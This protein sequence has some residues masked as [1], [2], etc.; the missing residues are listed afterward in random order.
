MPS[1]V[2]LREDDSAEAL[3][4]L[5]RRSKD[6]NRNRRLLSWAVVRDGM[7]RGSAAQIGAMD[8]Q[9]LR[10]WVHRFNA[11]GPDELIRQLDRGPRAPPVRRAAGCVRPDCR[12][13]FGSRPGPRRALAADRPQAAKQNR[14]EFSHMSGRRP[15]SRVLEVL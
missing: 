3:Q 9:T 10:D 6:V 14:A 1:A 7:D 5:A 8:R 12:G 11:S 4:A 15:V 2:R 13:Q